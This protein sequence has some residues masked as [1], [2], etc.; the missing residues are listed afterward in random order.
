MIPYTSLTG[1][2][3]RIPK[4]REAGWRFFVSA[5]NL[6]KSTQGFQYAIDNGAWTAFRKG[7]P[8]R[9]DQF[10]RALDLL[11]DEADFIVVPDIVE[12]GAD[13]LERTLEWLPRLEQ[14]RLVLLPVQDGFEPCQVIPYLSDRV[15]IFLGGSTGWKERTIPLWGRVAREAQCYYHV[16]RVNSMR[17]I[18][19]CAA[20]GANSFDG[21]SPAIF[22]DK[23]ARLDVARRQTSFV[24]D[25]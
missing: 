2:K 14:Y 9:E 16:G 20:A 5:T 1:N 13:S 12:G 17:R 6:T 15:G 11:G 8:W 7:I 10:V 25:Y 24:F 22:P 21:S 18:Y 4:L 23:L 3:R 19:R